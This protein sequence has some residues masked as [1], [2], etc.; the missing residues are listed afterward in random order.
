MVDS[1]LGHRADGMVDPG[2]RDAVMDSHYDLHLL[3]AVCIVEAVRLMDPFS[4]SDLC[5]PHTK[6][7]VEEEEEDRCDIHA[8]DQSLVCEGL[9]GRTAEVQ[10]VDDGPMDAVQVVER[11]GSGVVGTVDWEEEGAVENFR[12]SSAIG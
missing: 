4:P 12:A 2:L 11:M 8:R 6:E 5:V 9:D 3:T 7:V 1:W 10:K